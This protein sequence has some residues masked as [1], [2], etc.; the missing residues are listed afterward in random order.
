MK[1]VQSLRNA[2]MVSFGVLACRYHIGMGRH[3]FCTGG[4]AGVRA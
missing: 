4:F 1:K 3:R 2:V